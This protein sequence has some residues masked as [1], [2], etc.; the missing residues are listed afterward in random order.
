MTQS[1]SPKH[2]PVGAFCLAAALLAVVPPAAWAQSND[3]AARDALRAEH[4]KA[5][6]FEEQVEQLTQENITLKQQLADEKAHGD[7]LRQKAEDAGGQVHKL[8]QAVTEANGK[9][10]AEQA[11]AGSVVDKWRTQYEALTEQ[12]KKI[13]A[14]RHQFAARAITSERGLASCKDKNGKLYKIGLDLIKPLQEQGT[15]RCSCR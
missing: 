6:Q 12:A 1:H 14:E 15:W 7:A 4:R 9:V 13:D 2:S 5:L 10:Q 8:E 11:E 3:A